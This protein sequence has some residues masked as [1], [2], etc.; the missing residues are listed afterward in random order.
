MKIPYYPGCTL[1]TTAKNFGYGTSGIT[2]LELL[3]HGLFSGKRQ[4]YGTTRANPQ[5]PQGKRTGGNR[6][7]NS[8]FDVLQHSQTGKSAGPER[9][10]EKRKDKAVH[11]QGKGGI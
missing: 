5:S 1:K 11:G 6:I 7:G 2:P 8:L 10:R 3:R 4:S 9:L